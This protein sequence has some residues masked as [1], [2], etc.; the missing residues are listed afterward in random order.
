MN[1][2]VTAKSAEN[3]GAAPAGAGQYLDDDS[4]V[5][6]PPFSCDSYGQ[7]EKSAKIEILPS[8]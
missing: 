8:L 5:P 6:V 3:R 7:P 2:L 4:P 1:L